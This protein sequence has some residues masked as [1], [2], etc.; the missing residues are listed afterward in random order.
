MNGKAS[1][2][3]VI[4]ALL[5][6][7]CI[8][9]AAAAQGVGAIGGTVVDTSG[10]VLPG[11]TV[12]LANPGTIGGN[13][14]TVSDEHG[15]YRFTRLVPGRYTVRADLQGFRAALQEDVVVN[16]D[17]TVRVD[18]KLEVGPLEEGITVNGQAPLLDTTSALNQTVMSR[19][20]LDSLPNRSDLWAIARVIPSVVLGK[21]DVGGSEAFLQ[22]STTVHGSSN[23]NGYFVDGMDVSSETGNGS[24]A[25][26][27]LDPFAFQETNYQTGNGPAERS[28]G[29]VIFNEI[30]KSG[31]NTLHGGYMFSGANHGL[32]SANYSPALKAQLLT[33]VPA[34]ALA[35]NPNIVPGADIQ[36]IW[37]TGAWL[38]GP[39]I[40]DKLWYATSF[41][42]QHL[43][44]FLLGNYDTNGAQVLDDNIMWTIGSKLSW[45]ATRNSQLSYF[46]NVQYKLIG[47]RN[48]GGLFAD[49]KARN[50]SVKYPQV[51]QVKWTAPISSKIV[52]DVSGSL[53]RVSDDFR[54][55]PGVSQGDI[56]HFDSVT[57]TYT[58]AL[59]TYHD[60]PEQRSVFLASMNY[61]LG[62]H[63]V[64]VG[65]QYMREDS[66]FP[67][68]STSGM[69]A[70]FRNGV[71]DSVNTYNTPNNST[72]FDSTHAVY[73][74]D[75][76]R[77]MRKLT[78]NLGLRFETN[79]GWQPATCQPQTQFVTG[80]CFPAIQGAPDWKALAPRFS[81]VYDLFGDGKTV[82]KAA[83][84][85][86]EIPPGVSFVAQINPV[87]VTSD[88]RAWSDLNGDRI[89]QLNE[90]GPSS[91]FNFGTTNRYGPTMQWP[92]ANEYSLEVQHQ[93]PG[94]VVVS[95]SYTRRETRRNIGP[96]NVAVPA[97]SYIPL[98]VTEATSGRLV[99]VYNQ[100]PALRGK[101]DVLWD[102]LSAL[103]A[104][105]NGA[106]LTVD[107]RLSDRWMLMAGASFGRTRGDIYCNS[108]VSCTATTGDL[109]S[110]NLQFRH[111]LVGN[112]V[113]V[114][115]RA[116]GVHQMRWGVSVSATAQH[117]TGF[118]ENTTVLVG[119]NTARLTQVTQ[120]LVVEPRGTT[121]PPSVNSLDVS[122]RK[123]WKYHNVA[124]EPVM[125][126]Y[127][128]LNA[129]SLLSRI[130]QL[131]PTYLTPA[132]I[133]RGRLIRLGVN[134][135]F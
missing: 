93:L 51:N 64:K 39:I 6:F 20:V 98:Q 5:F 41:H 43:N 81:V 115:L 47:H 66:G 82:L 117:Y 40:R 50:Y 122:L 106:D 67:Y 42:D 95:A 27:Y 79:Y 133:Q 28:R 130:T 23:E 97:D 10:G 84:N 94:N 90:L 129:A 124:L 2:G 54:P 74:Q 114:S 44:Q 45:Q 58:A 9:L 101:F 59:P 61:I 96:Q 32:G 33:A 111:G 62:D 3:R 12:T 91:G 14:T 30:T 19:E 83:A 29:G 132:T 113:P 36:D 99:T 60:N 112:D 121:R 110:P 31:T 35:A 17:V 38:G 49:S 119:A 125:D 128:L 123:T 127:N 100:N 68:T 13:Q 73:V 120:S 18:L 48:G 78:L 77:A 15:T 108:L 109:N 102:N 56:S 16:A 134:V 131:G 53:M 46:Y 85:R 21:L 75:K 135:N 57:N 70:V 118:P 116:S 103:D 126:T 87:V 69:R 89:P 80:Q 65:Y 55:E 52:L 104:T 4:S 105:Y 34:T 92:V 1:A 26:I 37:D 88:T 63:D 72:Q 25:M 22:S 24:V 8:P 11:A 76:W 7:V 86:Y 107:K 71:P